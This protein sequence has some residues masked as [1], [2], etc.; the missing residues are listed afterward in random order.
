M[1]SSCVLI[2]GMKRSM[3]KLV[4]VPV[5]PE[6]QRSTYE[7]EHYEGGKTGPIDQKRRPRSY[8]D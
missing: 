5:E 3:G 4:E 1:E 7:R 6:L 2:R 8:T